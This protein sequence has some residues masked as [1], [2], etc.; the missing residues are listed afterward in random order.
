M[1]FTSLGVSELSFFPHFVIYVSILEGD[2]RKRN[3]NNGKGETITMKLK[4]H[5]KKVSI[6]MQPINPIWLKL[7]EFEL[8]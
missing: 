6:A 2:V 7:F 1:D 4:Q 3:I 8:I 5:S